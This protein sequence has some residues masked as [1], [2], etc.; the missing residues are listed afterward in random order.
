MTLLHRIRLR[1]LA[2]VCGIALAAFAMI[3]LA[4]LPAWPVI[5]I[6]VAAVAFSVNTL[7]SRLGGTACMGC[8]HDLA[9]APSGAYGI[10]CGECGSI[11][12]PKG[13]RA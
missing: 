2:W 12:A 11:N 13:P 5:G 3:S 4:S 9:G 10:A 6:A 7:T 1:V 8:G